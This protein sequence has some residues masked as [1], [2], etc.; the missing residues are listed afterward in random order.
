M[1]KRQDCDA[2]RLWDEIAAR[3]S[4]FWDEL[5]T[6]IALGDFNFEKAMASLAEHLLRILM[7]F[8][9]PRCR[10]R[11]SA[12]TKGDGKMYAALED[13]RKK[14]AALDTESPRCDH[15]KTL[16]RTLRRLVKA[17]DGF[18]DPDTRKAVQCVRMSLDALQEEMDGE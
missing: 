11:S 17:A 7:P 8:V 10:R 3:S 14:L 18:Q 1:K 4:S 16:M 13:L 15:A 6:S 9:E 12:S 2:Q 5:T